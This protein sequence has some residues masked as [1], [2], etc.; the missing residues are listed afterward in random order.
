M[1]KGG[2]HILYSV[3]DTKPVHNMK[4]KNIGQGYIEQDV[5]QHWQNV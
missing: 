3:N 4:E 5:F 1:L 2:V